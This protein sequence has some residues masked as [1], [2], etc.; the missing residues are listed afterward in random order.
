[1][2]ERAD[3][4][5][6]RFA[7]VITWRAGCGGSRT[8][9]SGSGLRKRAGRKTE[10]APQTDF[11]TYIKTWDGWAFLATVIDL[12][13]RALVGWALGCHMRTSLVTDALQM[14]LDRRQ[15]TGQVIFHSDRG[16]QYTSGMFADFCALNNVQR[17][18]GRT[19]TCYDNAVAESSSQ[20]SRRNSSTPSRGRR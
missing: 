15:P 11:H 16:T 7:G 3:T 10:T 9:G 12:H 18:M 4:N 20:R 5:I 2:V 13:S 1:M 19:G 8:S 6:T 14:A 17:S